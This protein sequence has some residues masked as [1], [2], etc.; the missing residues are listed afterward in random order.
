M[1]L[2]TYISRNKIYVNIANYH[3]GNN[4]RSRPI[5]K[6]LKKIYSVIFVGGGGIGPNGSVVP[7]ISPF[8]PLYRS[9]SPAPTD[10]YVS[11]LL[12]SK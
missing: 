3:K 11:A 12:A 5:L 7:L 2:S 6:D 1:L 8:N 4:I 9:E 10:L